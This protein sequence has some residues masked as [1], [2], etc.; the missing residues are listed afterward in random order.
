[1]GEISFMVEILQNQ[2]SAT[3]FRV[4]VEIVANQP[5]I[6][7]KQI[8]GRLEITPQAV[9]DYIKQ[10]LKDG[11]LISEGRSKYRLSI[12]G[13]DW[14]IKQIRTTKEYL[15]QAE[16]LIGNV[17]ISGAIAETAIRKGQGVGLLMKDGMLFATSDD[18]VAAQG[19]A[20]SDA[21]PGEDVGIS[22]IQG[23]IE[24]TV[25]VVTIAELPA[26]QRGGSARTNL[27]KLS[28]EIGRHKPIIAIGVEAITALQRID[29][30]PDYTY[31]ATEVTIDAARLGLSP[32]VICIDDET[33]FIIRRLEESGLEHNLVNLK[34]P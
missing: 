5:N 21:G 32:L 11:L 17:R 13:I 16:Q 31:A 2:N 18:C 30:K 23:I 19:T 15:A 27:D 12:E 3:R 20:E 26:I 34:K 4:M 29:S 6:Q 24:L 1:M 7:Q 10:L 9:S 8:A 14:M 33:P 28:H 25:G 22:N